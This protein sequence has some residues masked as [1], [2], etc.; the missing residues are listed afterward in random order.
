[1]DGPAGASFDQSHKTYFGSTDD[2][3]TYRHKYLWLL[4][5]GPADRHETQ[6]P[7]F[8]MLVCR[9]SHRAPV[10]HPNSHQGVLDPPTFRMHLV[11]RGGDG[12]VNTK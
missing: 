11:V 1:M 5:I 3:I 6:A 8:A 12:P 10:G 9:P 4:Q 7:G 2:K